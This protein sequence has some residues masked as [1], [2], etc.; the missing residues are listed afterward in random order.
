VNG[1]PRRS[2]DRPLIL[3]G[4][5]GHGRVVAELV[6]ACGG[7]L[8]GV[9]D[10]SLAEQGTLEWH[11][12]PVLGGD[13]YLENVKPGEVLLLNGIGMMPGSE[14]R[15]SVFQRLSQSG[16][17]FPVLVHRA[18]WVAGSV[19]LEPGVQV[20]AGAVL[21]PGVTVGSNSIIN[22]GSS[23]DHDSV[24]G[25]HC[26]IAPGVTLCGDVEVGNHVFVGAGATLIQGVVLGP[27]VFVKA[28]KVIT[29]NVV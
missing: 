22:T 3:L 19:V 25:Q 6:T 24:I 2:F 23:V 18:A 17:E 15:R 11:G 21:Q 16:F 12:L 13:E 5:G 14:V 27:D 7:T 9:C 8:L 20:M 4:A 28:G 10:P 29:R 1:M 26:H